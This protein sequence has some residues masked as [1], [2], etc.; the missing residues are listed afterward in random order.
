ME[1]AAREREAE[2]SSVPRPRGRGGGEPLAEYRAK[3]DF[4]KTPEP[5]PSRRRCGEGGSLF[6]VQKHAAR[7]LHYDFR[8][9]MDGVL[10][11]WAIPKG[12]PLAANERRL[13]M[14]TEDHP[15]EYARFEGVIPKGQYGGGTVMVWDIGRY[16]IVDGSYEKGKLHLRLDGQKLRGEW[17]LVRSRAGA[18]GR[19]SW[20]CIKTGGA[21]EI[22]AA[23]R[24]RSALTGRSMEEIA[25]A[26]DAVWHGEADGVAES[27]PGEPP[28]DLAALPRGE[29]TFVKPM[30]CR[31]VSELPAGSRWLYEF[32]LGGLRAQAVRAEEGAVLF[33]ATGK[34]LSLRFPGLVRALEALPVQSVLDGEVVALDEQGRPSRRLLRGSRPT[35][36]H[37]YAFDILFYHGRKTVGLPLSERRRWLRFALSSVGPPVRLSEEF[38]ASPAELVR[39]AREL[40]LA[41]VIAKR[42]DSRYRSGRSG[43]WLEYRLRKAGGSRGPR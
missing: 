5:P 1:R 37:F 33:S 7:R 30:L 40:G 22:P 20:L 15:L 8:L 26:R 43:A 6:V 27:T 11:S 25:A 17:V 13:A 16:E 39:A 10:K 35:A 18:G 24:E 29:A 9:E 2:D 31:P 34:R 14:P 23:Q 4:G 32:G 38:D 12:P 42:R 41:S 19:E 28:G 21:A 36:V 3:R